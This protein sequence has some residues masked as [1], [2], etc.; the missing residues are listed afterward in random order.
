MNGR[1]KALL[2]WGLIAFVFILVNRKTHDAMLGVVKAFLNIKIVAPFLAMFFY[3]GMLLWLLNI[4]GLW[5]SALLK[6][7]IFWLFG[8][9][10]VLFFNTNRASQNPSLLKKMLLETVA[11]TVFLEFL[12][13]LY[14]FSFLAEFTLMPLLFFVVA[15]SAL[16]DSKD[17]Y[18]IVRKPLKAILA[19]YGLFVLPYSIFTAFNN[20]F[21]S[22][23]LY[24]LLSLVIPSV[25]TVMYLPFIYLFALIMAYEL[26]FVRLGSLMRG[27]KELARFTKKRILISFG[28]NLWLLNK[29]AQNSA[30]DILKLKNENG[31]FS[32]LEKYRKT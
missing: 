28:L 6:D 22:L 5:N 26:L 2:V 11:F 4:V 32:M 17:V 8:T 14:S 31:V 23:T 29:F 9:A 7:T 20:L 15:M 25:L 12:A 19:G 1:E 27:N 30:A 18:R 10:I 3:S 24:N 21:E 16:A 13:N